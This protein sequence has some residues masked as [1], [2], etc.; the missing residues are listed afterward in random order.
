MGRLLP[1][2]IVDVRHQ[3]Y[4]GRLGHFTTHPLTWTKARRVLATFHATGTPAKI[5]CLEDL[6]TLHLAIVT[7]E[8]SYDEALDEAE[9][10]GYKM[11]G[12]P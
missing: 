12:D 6:V 7:G 9:R 8:L 10:L 4:N 1:C 2:W 11:K 5:L 3:R